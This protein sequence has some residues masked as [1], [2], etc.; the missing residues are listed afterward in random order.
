MRW[1]EKLLTAS[2]PRT[3]KQVLVSLSLQAF[4]VADIKNWSR[5]PEGSISQ[6]SGATIPRE[7]THGLGEE[8]RCGSSLPIR[9][10]IWNRSPDECVAVDRT[11][12]ACHLRFRNAH[13]AG[14]KVKGCKVL[15]YMQCTEANG[16]QGTSTSDGSERGQ[17]KHEIN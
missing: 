3:R 16:K 15:R 1:L 12:R 7:N 13:G 6:V 2:L 17:L 10:N 5:S 11:S 8:P 14:G 4:F 9:A